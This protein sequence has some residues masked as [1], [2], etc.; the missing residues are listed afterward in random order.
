MII[1]TRETNDTKAP[2]IYAVPRIKHKAYFHRI[3]V[4]VWS[5]QAPIHQ[6]ALPLTN[7]QTPPNPK[8]KRNSSS[9]TILLVL[10]KFQA[11]SC[12][13]K[14]DYRQL[15]Y[16]HFA[17]TCIGVDIKFYSLKRCQVAWKLNHC[18]ESCGRNLHFSWLVAIVHFARCA[19]VNRY[20][21]NSKGNFG[22]PLYW[23]FIPIGGKQ[24][25]DKGKPKYT[26]KPSLI[27]D[28]LIIET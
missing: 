15:L 1:T 22:L 25:S 5:V 2:Y 3:C 26:C 17:Y 21:I 8:I 9:I 13:W 24:T 18:R 12:K 11:F 10:E 27:T 7:R 20:Y 16:N 6:L 19:P 14:I 28:V 4:R 23:Q